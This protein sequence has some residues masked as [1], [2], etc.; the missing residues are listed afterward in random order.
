MPIAGTPRKIFKG[1]QFLRVLGAEKMATD[2]FFRARLDGMVTPPSPTGFEGRRSISGFGAAGRLQVTVLDKATLRAAT[3]RLCP[4]HRLQIAVL[5]EATL[6][7]PIPTGGAAVG[8]AVTVLDEAALSLAGL[9]LWSAHAGPAVGG[10][11]PVLNEPAL[12]RIT[13]RLGTTPCLQIPTLDESA[14]R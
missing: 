7:A 11:I 9:T 5:D 14:L 4:A 6:A 3:A 13:V 10:G 1:L 8:P 2:D 12:R